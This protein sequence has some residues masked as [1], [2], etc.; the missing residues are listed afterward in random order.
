MNK[1]IGRID[2]NILFHIRE[3]LHSKFLYALRT[4]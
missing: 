3:E 1:F 4:G 2:S